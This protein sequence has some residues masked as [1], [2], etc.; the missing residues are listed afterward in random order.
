MASSACLA[1]PAARLAAFRPQTAPPLTPPCPVKQQRINIDGS[2]MEEE[3]ERFSR[4]ELLIGENGL[5]K[6]K[7][8]HVAVVGLGGVGSSSAQAL[9]RAGIGELTFIDGDCVSPSNINRQLIAF[10][11][12]IGKPKAEIMRQMAQSINPGAI[13]HAFNQFYKDGDF[14]Y[15][16]GRTHYIIDAIDMVSAK[17]SLIQCA[18][19][20]GIPIISA[21]GCGGRL[22]PELFK[23][24]DIY[25]T[26]VCPLC[27]VMR[28]ELK[29]RGIA[30]LKV[31]YSTE[32][33]I[34]PEKRGVIGSISFTPPA[35]G[36]M[37]AGQ[38]VRDIL[39]L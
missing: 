18:K 15:L 19:Q 27:R 8:V 1:G 5:E 32:E 11:S 4:T 35:A 3:K 23:I 25:S 17:L 20:R 34:K 38:A 37:L 16:L 26:S 30:S 21:M 12:T 14:D 31:V 7:N 24:A 10:E 2:L 13:I 9:V 36:L 6:L 22:N 29:K 28:R 33:P 39:S